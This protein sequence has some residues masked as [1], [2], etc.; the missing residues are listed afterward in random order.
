MCRSS[1]QSLASLVALHVYWC[2]A[3]PLE[4]FQVT[5]WGCYSWLPSEKV[6]DHLYTSVIVSCILF[7]GLNKTKTLVVIVLYSYFLW[8]VHTVLSAETTQEAFWKDWPAEFSDWWHFHSVE[9]RW[10]TKWSCCELRWCWSCCIRNI[11]IFLM[12]SQLRMLNIWEY[13]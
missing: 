10:R 3:I 12:S 8:L 2:L 4:S 5:I 1:S 13:S 9:V 6:L 11:S 7:H